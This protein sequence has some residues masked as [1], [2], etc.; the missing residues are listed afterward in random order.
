MCY[1]AASA[2]IS[3]DQVAT[4][5]WRLLSDLQRSA[6]L[7]SAQEQE[8]T[9]SRSEV[10]ALRCE[11]EVL[12]RRLEVLGAEAAA[13]AAV[14]AGDAA[15]LEGAPAAAEEESLLRELRRELAALRLEGQ[16]AMARRQAE[17]A[18]ET[19][20]L[21]SRLWASEARLRGQHFDASLELSRCREVG[22]EELRAVETCWALQRGQLE[23]R[24]WRAR[25][26]CTDA[27]QR[28]GS[29]SS[30]VAAAEQRCERAGSRSEALG[31]QLAAQE[32]AT[33]ELQQQLRE[34]RAEAAREIA[35]RAAAVCALAARLE[36]GAMGRQEDEAR[37]TSELAALRLGGASALQARR[38][39]HAAEVRL[40]LGEVRAA[41]REQ[42]LR[43]SAVAA[44]HW[45][46]CEEQSSSFVATAQQRCCRATDAM[47]AAVQAAL[48]AQRSAREQLQCT[49]RTGCAQEA[50]VQCRALHVRAECNG[51]TRE[52]QQLRSTERLLGSEL[53]GDRHAE[54]VALERSCSEGAERLL[55][56]RQ[57]VA[58]F[59]ATSTAL[60]GRLRG[61]FD[62]A[63]EVAARCRGGGV[64]TAAMG[65]DVAAGLRAELD[66]CR[67]AISQICKMAE[68]RASDPAFAP[69][70]IQ[71]ERLQAA[72]REH[73]AAARRLAATASEVDQLRRENEK[74]IDL[75]NDLRRQDDGLGSGLGD[76]GGVAVAAGPGGEDAPAAAAAE[77]REHRAELESEIQELLEA[78]RELRVELRAAAGGTA[79]PADLAAGAGRGGP[80]RGCRVPPSP[81]AGQPP[82]AGNLALVG[83]ALPVA[84]SAPALPR[85][86][87]D[88]YTLDQRQVWTRIRAGQ[89]RQTEELA[90]Q[91]RALLP[92]IRW[93]GAA[94]AQATRDA[95]QTLR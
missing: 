93:A 36:C 54:L 53:A 83:Q 60:C 84:G 1:A 94:V 71:E 45:D 82:V 30:Q 38:E 20:E 32:L 28:Q 62:V 52:L 86:A 4:E 39:R 15:V 29:L 56:L 59:E 33:D 17:A 22:A 3:L 42:E 89:R 88:R 12:G 58:H 46:A 9:A 27:E 43:A 57:Q 35:A 31:A 69:L 13:S 18:A 16:T 70:A 91:R 92:V 81:P 2:A 19:T 90:A 80:Y 87:S 34:S 44:Q 75:H 24:L 68:A 79:A 26:G 8:L 50:E 40:R 72:C 10:A 51:L 65:G 64:L 47:R 63:R 55:A 74:L 23:V 6:A 66:H 77:C 78:H 7:A 48:A 61:D 85:S 21:R 76:G 67:D 41:C 14:D 5:R 25:Q 37:R 49:V 11:A 73:E 95:D